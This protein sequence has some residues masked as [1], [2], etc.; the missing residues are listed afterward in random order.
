MGRPARASQ[1]HWFRQAHE[2]K[3]DPLP[4]VA[5]S[6]PIPTPQSDGRVGDEGEFDFAGWRRAS[7]ISSAIRRRYKGAHPVR[8]Q[9]LARRLTNALAAGDEK[10]IERI[11]GERINPFPTYQERSEMLQA[12]RLEYECRIC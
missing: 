3:P 8:Q 1:A 10:G 9:R 11:L 4:E 5:E 7:W 6:C 12:A 2:T